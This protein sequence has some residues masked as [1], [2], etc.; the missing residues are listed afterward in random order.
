MNL[1]APFIAQF[2]KGP[3]MDA[4]PHVDVLF[5]NESV[6]YFT[7]LLLFMFIFIPKEKSFSP[8]FHIL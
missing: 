8:D 1:S 5:G 6:R 4:M 7:T 2:F 3:L